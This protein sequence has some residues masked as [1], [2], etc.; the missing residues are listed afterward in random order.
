MNYS[1]NEGAA[2]NPNPSYLPQNDGAD[3]QIKLDKIILQAPVPGEP[4]VISQVDGQDDD[5]EEEEVII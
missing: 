4:T 5:D 1:F 3:E 2:Y